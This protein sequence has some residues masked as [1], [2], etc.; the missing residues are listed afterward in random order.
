MKKVILTLLVPAL[1]IAACGD[2]TSKEDSKT[3]AELATSHPGNKTQSQLVV[4]DFNFRAIGIDT[5][6][7]AIFNWGQWCR[8]VQTSS[9]NLPGGNTPVNTR[10][11]NIGY[12]DLL[13]V[14]GIN[15]PDTN[16]VKP[17]LKFFKCRAYIGLFDDSLHLYMTP[18]NIANGKDSILM[19]NGR[20]VVYDLITPCPNTCDPSS[21]LYQAYSSK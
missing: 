4:P 18:V 7:S 14:L 11:F 21:I 3:K 9:C 10:A 2:K 20:Q 6:I 17:L 5:A 19:I 15:G 13:G 12:Q 8:G 1:L 16:T